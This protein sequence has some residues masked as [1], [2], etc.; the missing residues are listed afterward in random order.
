MFGLCA[1][2]QADRNENRAHNR[3]KRRKR[4]L[5]ARRLDLPD[6]AKIFDRFEQVLDDMST[7]GTATT[8]F[9]SELI[10]GD[11]KV[12]AQELVDCVL[13]GSAS[14]GIR[15]VQHCGSRDALFDRLHSFHEDTD[16]GLEF[17]NDAR[18]ELDF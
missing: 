4:R 8:H 7:I 13:F 3:R 10:H 2:L 16:R 5:R 1:D 11:K 6:L 15:L 14:E 9:A 17:F 18:I 12:T